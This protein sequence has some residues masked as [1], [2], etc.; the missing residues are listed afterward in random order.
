[1]NLVVS[2]LLLLLGICGYFGASA[3]GLECYKCDGDGCNNQT[4]T[5]VSCASDA[6]ANTTTTTISTT[7]ISP[8]TTNSVTAVSES[9]STAF[10]SITESESTTEFASSA[11]T[12]SATESISMSESTTE[13]FTTMEGNTTSYSTE[14]TETT[15]TTAPDQISYACYSIRYKDG[16]NTK[17][18]KGCVATNS[19]ESACHVLVDSTSA[20]VEKCNVCLYSR[21]NSSSTIKLSILAILSLVFIRYII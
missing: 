8:S 1:M 7:T 19:N 20:P 6:I 21:C 18:Q 17:T 9:N 11:S 12:E 14:L 5:I 16:D 13:Y 2:L 4:I 15:S 3:S 10:E